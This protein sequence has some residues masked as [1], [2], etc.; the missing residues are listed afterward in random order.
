MRWVRALNR[1]RSL[2]ARKGSVMAMIPFVMCRPVDVRTALAEF[3]RLRAV[4][5]WLQR[6]LHMH[7]NSI[8]ST[9]LDA[10]NRLELAEAENNRL[11]E[12]LT[13]AWDMVTDSPLLETKFD[14]YLPGWLMTV[15]VELDKQEE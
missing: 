6:R 2:R 8:S 7:E 4:N 1:E 5:E 14:E 9:E 11:R 3:T 13:Q 12:L 10:R 15:A